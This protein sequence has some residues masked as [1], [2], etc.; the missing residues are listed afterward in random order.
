MISKD[1]PREEKEEEAMSEESELSKGS[2]WTKLSKV[3]L[4]GKIESE[5]VYLRDEKKEEIKIIECLSVKKSCSIS[6]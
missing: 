5:A 3:S 2:E 6:N 1:N 4:R